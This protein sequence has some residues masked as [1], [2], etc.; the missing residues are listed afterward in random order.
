MKYI[1][2]FKN[3]LEVALLLLNHFKERTKRLYSADRI[4]N[5]NK[6]M[7][8]K[9]LKLGA[10]LFQLN[11][12]KYEEIRITSSSIPSG[13]RKQSTYKSPAN[14]SQCTT[15]FEPTERNM[16]FYFTAYP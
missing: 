14:E 9:Q 4:D 16:K 10:T 8:P 3:Q 1:E 6:Q 7:Y 15:L 2:N 13:A 11:Y 5:Y 12:M